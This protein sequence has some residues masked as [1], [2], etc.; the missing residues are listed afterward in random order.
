MKRTMVIA[1]AVLA[2]GACA[3]IL[4]LR[5]RREAAFP[6]RGHV[7]AG[8]SCLTCHTPVARAGDTDPVVLPDAASC[9]SCH[10]QPHDPRDCMTC[11]ADPWNAGAVV[12]ARLHLRFSHAAHVPLANGNCARCHQDV[13]R[14]DG[15]I[16]PRMA[17]CLGCHAHADQFEP[18]RCDV[19]H[20]DLEEEGTLPES[21]LVHDGDWLR[22]HGAQA[23]SDAAMC[24]TCHTERSC[25]RC[26]G[27]T[28]PV[29]PARLAF[30]EPDGLGLHR[31]GFRSRHA[32]EAR[33]NPGMCSACHDDGAC[34]DCHVA[35]GVAAVA[36]GTASPHPPGWVGVGPAANQHGP[37]ARRDPAA[38]ASCHG[39]AGEQLCVGCHKVGGVGG[40]PHPPGWESN[41]P[42]TA[43]PC[44]LCH[45]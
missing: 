6:H 11:H 4:G 24:S 28:A 36:P 14:A 16:R 7:R 27:V 40:S 42:R 38:C 29:V 22:N 5:P 34:R 3:G 2:L 23:A 43:L 19:C 25:A 13:A 9:T 32:E 20:V 39:G 44:R 17:T 37:A 1:I 26:H 10:T 12:E 8:V 15:P 41:Q 45:L 31:A 33:A 35:E 18:T 30:D 21:H